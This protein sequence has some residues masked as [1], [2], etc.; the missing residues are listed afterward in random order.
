MNLKMMKY[1]ILKLNK[2]CFKYKSALLDVENKEETYISKMEFKTVIDCNKHITELKLKGANY[3]KHY[4]KII[5]IVPEKF[6]DYYEK[7]IQ[8]FNLCELGHAELNDWC[9]IRKL[10]V[11]LYEAKEINKEEMTYLNN[12]ISFH[13]KTRGRALE[14]SN[15]LDKIKQKKE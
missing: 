13:F 10:T 14:L 12:C 2:N 6:D 7:L 5:E 15:L 8:F 11:K 1:S 3:E 9:K 4:N